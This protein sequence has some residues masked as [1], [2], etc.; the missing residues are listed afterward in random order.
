MTPP[1][2]DPP[3]TPIW[4]KLWIALAGL[5]VAGAAVLDFAT[6]AIGIVE[7]VVECYSP[8]S[9]AL[10]SI[11]LEPVPNGPTCLKF[12]FERLPS[13]F[14]LGKIRFTVIAISGLQ[15]TAH[16]AARSV[17]RQGKDMTV[18]T[19]VMTG[20]RIEIDH[21]I[22]IQAQKASD[23]AVVAVCPIPVDPGMS[24]NV[25]VVPS[26]LSLAGQ[27]I[28]NIETSTDDGSLID[29]GIELAVVRYPSPSSPNF[30]TE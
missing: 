15:S 3:P 5:A 6:G 16:V 18:P 22:D 1:Q 23:A 17:Y 14:T 10:V 21:D 29:D 28:E 2:T 7:K 8:P 30:Q 9:P 19:N 4:K 13:D 12:S 20:E 27:P 11:T 25:T 24:A 26:F